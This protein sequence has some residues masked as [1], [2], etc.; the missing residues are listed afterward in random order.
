[1]TRLL[2]FLLLLAS[3]AAAQMPPTPVYPMRYYAVRACNSNGVSA[4][5]NEVATNV[6]PVALMWDAS[7]TPDVYYQILSGLAS[8]VYTRTNICTGLTID[9]PVFM[10][11]DC[12]V[13]LTDDGEVLYCATNPPGAMLFRKLAGE[14]DFSADGWNWFPYQSG[15]SNQPLVMTRTDAR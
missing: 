10:P 9:L 5:S 3:V 1:M 15:C 13:T 2:P 14:V 7:T 12:V 4:N 6:W 11:V 8:G